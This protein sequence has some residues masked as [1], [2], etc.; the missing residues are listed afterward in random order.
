MARC[1]ATTRDGEQCRVRAKEGSEYCQRHARVLSPVATR[2]P[3]SENTEG[4]PS[5]SRSRSRSTTRA[6][7]R[8]LETKT[9]AAGKYDTFFGVRLYS[10]ERLANMS[11]DK[12][13]YTG[14]D[15][16]P[17]ALYILHPFW[18]FVVECVPVY[19]TYAL[20]LLS[21]FFLILQ[22][23]LGMYPSPRGAMKR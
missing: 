14:V 7:G 22:G 17:I 18:N 3:R 13:K 10:K 2:T 12:Y 5:R 19:V 15:L 11:I 21:F 16:S 8:S 20:C 23:Q 6:D 9:A 4:T 1:S